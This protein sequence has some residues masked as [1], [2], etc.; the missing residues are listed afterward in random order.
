MR[1]YNQVCMISANLEPN[2]R[3]AWGDAEGSTGDYPQTFVTG[4]GP[5]TPS[6]LPSM[7][8]EVGAPRR[9]FGGGDCATY[10]AARLTVEFEASTD[11]WLLV[12]GNPLDDPHFVLPGETQA[13]WE[14]LDYEGCFALEQMNFLGEV[15]TDA[16]ELCI[17]E[18]GPD[19]GLS[20]DAA[21][22]TG[23]E[24]GDDA[25]TNETGPPPIE[26]DASVTTPP[27]NVDDGADGGSI[28]DKPQR[29]P[30][31]HRAQERGGCSLSARTT[32]SVVPGLGM[33]L[34][35]LVFMRRR[36]Q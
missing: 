25:I 14:T 1:G 9:A 13:S 3:Y 20:H 10:Q 12:S 30:W 28:T 4:N 2:T 36:R 35:G 21:T 18:P 27:P 8:I 5:K 33:F 22:D 31:C 29:K 11:A 32:S 23:D 17:E 6:P 7:T 19:S 24:D 26:S 34:L 16:H 15:V